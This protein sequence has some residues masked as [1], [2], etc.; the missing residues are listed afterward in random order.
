[1]S[2]KCAVSANLEG[3]CLLLPTLEAT[4]GPGVRLIGVAELLVLT[5]ETS[6]ELGEDDSLLVTV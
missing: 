6:E 2:M 4:L 3:F 5:F 1:M